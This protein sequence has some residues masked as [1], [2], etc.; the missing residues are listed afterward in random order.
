[1]LTTEKPFKLTTEMT[2]TGDQPGA[3][4]DIESRLRGGEKAITDRKSVV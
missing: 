3:I 2:P 4:A 1:M